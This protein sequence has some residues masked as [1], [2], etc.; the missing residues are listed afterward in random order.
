MIQNGWSGGAAVNGALYGGSTVDESGGQINVNLFKN[1]ASN[2]SG[3]N[4]FYV[5]EGIYLVD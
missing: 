4:D 1:G 2:Q 3:A 5:A